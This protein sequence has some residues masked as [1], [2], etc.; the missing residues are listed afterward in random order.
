MLLFE[1]I[2]KKIRQQIVLRLLT[3][4][5]ILLLITTALTAYFITKSKII[6]IRENA[7]SQVKNAAAK[8]TSEL[9]IINTLMLED[10]KTSINVL[11]KEGSLLGSPNLGTNV[12]VGSEMV[13]GLKFGSN[14][15]ANNFSLVD[16]ATSLTGGVATLFVRSGN[17]FIRVSTNIKKA[18][19][20]RATGTR[21]DPNGKAI[22]A[23]REN[24]SFYGT[25]DILGETYITGYEPM[26]DANQNVIGIWFCGYPVTMLKQVGEAIAGICI[27]DQGF[28]ALINNNNKPAFKSTNTPE[29][30]L[31]NLLGDKTEKTDADWVV[32]KEKFTP[33]DYTILTAYNE[34]D[35]SSQVTSVTYSVLGVSILL[36][37]LLIVIL[38]VMV[39]RVVG[40]PIKALV[41]VADKLALGDIDS[42]VTVQSENEIGQLQNSFKTVIE[43]LALKVEA[44][45][46][47]A[48]GDVN[49]E[50]IVRS[51]KD[52]LSISMAQMIS[53]LQQ[54]VHETGELTKAAISGNMRK[55]GNAAAFQGSYREIV[56]GVN[57]TLD[58]ISN[59]IKEGIAVLEIMAG[60]DFT[61]RISSDYQGDHQKIK[62]GIN[63]VS[64]SLVAALHE[65]AEAVSATAS[66]STEISSS[67]EQ[68]SSG[69]HEQTQQINEIASAIEEMTKTILES[70]KNTTYATEKAR[71]AGT[72]AKDGGKIVKDT[73]DGMDRIAETV[74]HSAETVRALGNRSDEIGAIIQVIDDIADQTNLL[75]LNAAIEAARAGEQ[76]RGFAVVA[77]EVRKLAERT[78]KATKE[79]ATMIKQIQQETSGAVTIMAEGTREVELG[80]LLVHKAGESLTDII[81][82]ATIVLDVVAQVAATSEEQS[83]TSEQISK[84]IEG[85]SS[86]TQQSAASTQEIAHAAEDLNQ[87][88]VNLE[89]LI[90]QFKIDEGNTRPAQALARRH[91]LN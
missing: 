50:V 40:T 36:C 74:M 1:T 46:A 55:R 59:P 78:T 79:I 32:S 14:L 19:G 58:A 80:K 62:E 86:A 68:M 67:T 35:I 52:V 29:D 28:V 22:A 2:R 27:L 20:E 54:L 85:I 24:K 56:T 88:T 21:L 77:D 42:V 81:N 63:T 7:N 10:V 30:V 39:K 25:A 4:I 15:Q 8:I 90:S 43:N 91:R 53:T 84:N 34:S 17:D 64:D 6:A 9:T 37:G 33:W 13:P 72:K 82:S 49:T 18:G 89:N 23:I 71:D 41:A 75:A 76:G 47:L 60:G 38:V 70:T 87:L 65:V 12:T 44:A 83:A 31:T 66:A 3:P 5:V 69:A 16:G 45:K 51:D 61:H 48:H 11:R 26:H 73:I 57:N